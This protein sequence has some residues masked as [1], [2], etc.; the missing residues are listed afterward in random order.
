MA[1]IGALVMAS[2]DL[3][4]GNVTNCL[5]LSS[6]SMSKGSNDCMVVIKLKLDNTWLCLLPGKGNG[7]VAITSQWV[8]FS[9]QLHISDNHTLGVWTKKY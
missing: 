6:I 1:K 5:T 2:V 7:R 4:Y 3:K 9:Y 8:I